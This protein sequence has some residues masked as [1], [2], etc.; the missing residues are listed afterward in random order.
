[1]RIKYYGTAAAEGWPALFCGCDACREAARRG[2]KNI[3]T[4]SQA[5]IDGKLLIDF[6]PDTYLHMLFYGL[7]LPSFSH[8]IVTHAHEDHLYPQDVAMRAHGFSAVVK[9]GRFTLHGPD[10]VCRVMGALPDW[11]KDG[12]RIAWQE[13]FEY[14]PF[15]VEGYTVT[16]LLAAHGQFDAPARKCFI[17]D[18][19]KDGERLLYGNDTA[20]F[21]EA[22]WDFMRGRHYD[23]V[24]LDCTMLALGSGQTH[25]NIGDVLSVRDR[26]LSMGSAD[27]GTVWVINHFS[28]NGGLLHEELEE[29]MRPEGFHVAWDG[30]E[31]GTGEK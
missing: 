16:P 18:I 23:L 13:A 24:S 28:H 27:G 4:R 12:E 9:P 19:E 11:A 7:D 8:C 14:V 17:Y 20:V 2:G 29:I 3:R 21:P 22:T 30:F 1:M 15:E 6:P 5:A 31:I 10:A 25:M 26:L